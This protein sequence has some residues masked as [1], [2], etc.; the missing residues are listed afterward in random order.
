[1]PGA[2]TSFDTLTLELGERELSERRPLGQT[3]GE[4]PLLARL[5]RVAE[6]LTAEQN[7]TY[8]HIDAAHTQPPSPK[9][10]GLPA[11]IQALAASIYEVRSDQPAA[12]AIAEPLEVDAPDA[13]PTPAFTQPAPAKKDHDSSN[14][15]PTVEPELNLVGLAP[16]EQRQTSDAALA[17]PMSDEPMFNEPALERPAFEGPTFAPPRPAAE[18]IVNE[19]TGLLGVLLRLEAVIAPYSQIIVLLTLLAAA[20]LTV[21]LLRG[22]DASIESGPAAAPVSDTYQP[23][24]ANQ[25]P[26]PRLADL[27]DSAPG[28]GMPANSPSAA[29]PATA[30]GPIGLPVNLAQAQPLEPHREP[31]TAARAPVRTALA[32]LPYP[33]TEDMHTTHRSND[34]P[35]ARLTG[36]IDSQQQQTK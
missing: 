36:R 16:A 14:P 17:G 20:G 26:T 6:Q 22:S 33:T 35:V 32:P 30:T 34:R 2:Y 27:A 31:D 4:L 15:P 19:P 11:L 1:M 28:K 7:A 12:I 29:S 8:R 5:P 10:P 21:I 24:I 3:T 18:P 23:V 9:T 25:S 13:A